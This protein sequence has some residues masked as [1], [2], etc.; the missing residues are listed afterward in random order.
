MTER[1]VLRPARADE[2]EPVAAIKLDASRRY[3]EEYTTRPLPRDVFDKY[4]GSGSVVVAVTADDIPCGYSLAYDI[5]RDLYLRHLFVSHAFGQRGI[6]AALLR[7]VIDRAVGARNRAVTLTTGGNIPWN[8]PF[9]QRHGFAV[10]SEKMPEYLGVLLKA[11]IEHFSPE[12]LP[13]VLK[14]PYL[15]PRVAMERLT[16]G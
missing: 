15:L 16:A 5:D 6:G 4:V 10:L 13:L 1:C 7:G 2:Y 12:N 9:Y 8:A 11:E 3:G 14:Q